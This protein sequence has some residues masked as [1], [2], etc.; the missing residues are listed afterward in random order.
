[1][2]KD[3]QYNLENEN[4]LFFQSLLNSNSPSKPYNKYSKLDAEMEHSHQSFIDDTTQQQQA[5][6]DIIS[7]QT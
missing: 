3:N 6:S 7:I 5:S 1:M 2:S 4:K